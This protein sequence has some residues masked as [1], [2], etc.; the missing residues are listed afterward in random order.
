LLAPNLEPVAL[1]PGLKLEL[2]NKVIT[3]VHFPE[4]GIV[5]VVAGTAG[6]KEIEVGIKKA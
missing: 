1:T 4:A 5:S 3:H 2:P 6:R